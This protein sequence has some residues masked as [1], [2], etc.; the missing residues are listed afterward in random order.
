MWYLIH[1]RSK[2][3]T[4][5]SNGI[6]IRIELVEFEALDFQAKFEHHSNLDKTRMPL[7]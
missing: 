5:R 3:N 7:H 2:S 1:I 6:F 4:V